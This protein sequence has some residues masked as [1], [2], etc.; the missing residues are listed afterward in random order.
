[1][2]DQKNEILFLKDRLLSLEKKV[3]LV[4]EAYLKSASLSS[5]LSSAQQF[6]GRKEKFSATSCCQVIESPT[7]AR[8]KFIVKAQLGFV[9][10]S[11]CSGSQDDRLDR[12]IVTAELGFVETV[13]KQ[14]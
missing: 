11:A 7:G 14:G 8:N 2:Q 1:M 13:Y 10:P 5:D 4:R 3:S 9:L 12:N 6:R